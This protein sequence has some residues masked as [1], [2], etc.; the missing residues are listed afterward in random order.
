MHRS[1]H[2]PRIYLLAL[3]NGGNGKAEDIFLSK[4]SFYFVHAC[5]CIYGCASAS[6]HVY[7]RGE[8]PAL[9]VITQVP[10]VLW[11]F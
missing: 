9:G 8:R 4:Q 3:R 2:F 6:G 5:M 7:V 1:L 11:L 10:T